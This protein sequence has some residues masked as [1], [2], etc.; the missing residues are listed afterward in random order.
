MTGSGKT[1]VARKL[2]QVIDGEIICADSQQMKR[3]PAII[4]NKVLDDV[5]VHLIEHYS[6]TESMNANKYS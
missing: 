5:K 2:A 6:E 3:S 1:D 4:T